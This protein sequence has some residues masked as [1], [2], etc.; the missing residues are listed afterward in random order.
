LIIESH[1]VTARSSQR[2][3]SEAG[4]SHSRNKMNVLTRNCGRVLSPWKP[5]GLSLQPRSSRNSARLTIRSNQHDASNMTV[6]EKIIHDNIKV[7]V[8]SVSHS[9]LSS[10]KIKATGPISFANYMKLCLSH[11]TH[12]YY[13][14]HEHKVFGQSGDFITSPE[15]SQ[16]FGE[17]TSTSH[18]LPEV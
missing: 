17:V 3:Q 15:I 18:F 12:G 9:I 6:V 10:F 5:P 2:G 16:T 1:L 13:T 7:T 11:P 4:N 14:H 8:L